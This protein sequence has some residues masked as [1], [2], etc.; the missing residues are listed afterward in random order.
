V[1]ELALALADSTSLTP[2]EGLREV[3]G[4]PP[5][6][7]WLSE[8]FLLYLLKLPELLF[9]SFIFCFSKRRCDC[10]FSKSYRL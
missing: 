7:K 1:A 5:I 8:G 6:R 10:A 2:N 4:F 9:L 3:L